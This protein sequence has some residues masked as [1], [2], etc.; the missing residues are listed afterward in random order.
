[1][2]LSEHKLV[3]IALWMVT[4]VFL[5]MGLCRPVIEISVNVESVLKDAINQHPVVGLLL[6]EKGLKLSE[7]ASKLPPTSSTQQSVVSSIKKLYGIGSFTAATIILLFSVMF[8][9]LKQ[10]IYLIAMLDKGNTKQFVSWSTALHR[11]AMVDVFVLSLVVLT[12]SSAAAWSS[13]LLDGFFW[14]ILYFFTAA[15]L[16]SIVKR[17]T[18]RKSTAV[19]AVEA[20][21]QIIQNQQPQ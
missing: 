4:T 17:L 18:L 21:T 10:T 9:I 19:S 20:N 15:I 13:R 12:L 6:H 16:G 1:M 5:V 7:I 8:P 3:A 2:L 14:F 11:W